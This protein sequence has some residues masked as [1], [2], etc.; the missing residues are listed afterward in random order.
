[1]LMNYTATIELLNN[2]QRAAV[3]TLINERGEWSGSYR[4]DGP[5]RYERGY[6]R[7]SLEATLKGG[8]L[9]TYKRLS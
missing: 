4:I 6:D 3:I 1:M 7:A 5:N 8:R 2:G 9:S